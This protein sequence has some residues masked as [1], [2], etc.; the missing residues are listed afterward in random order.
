MG[1]KEK[2]R[3]MDQNWNKSG[4]LSFKH[5]SPFG[6]RSMKIVVHFFLKI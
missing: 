6:V 2:R 1:R 3:C 4:K 5:G